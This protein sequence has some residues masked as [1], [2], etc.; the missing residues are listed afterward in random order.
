V[1][2]KPFTQAKPDLLWLAQSIP[3]DLWAVSRINKASDR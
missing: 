2:R 1:V 3:G